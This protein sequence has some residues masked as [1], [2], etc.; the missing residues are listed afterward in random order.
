MRI[1]FYAPLKPPTHPTPSGDRR[2]ARL[3]MEA[4]RLAGH[5]VQLVSEFRSFDATGDALRQT[6]L[7]DEG[8]VIARALVQSWLASAQQ[9]RP[10]LWFTYHLYYKAPDWLGPH[11][12]AA[13]GIAYAIS[14]ASYAPRR[15]GG[16]WA[17]GHEATRRAIERAALVLCPTRDDIACVQDAAGTATRVLQLAPFLDPALYRAAAQSRAAQRMALVGAHGLSDAVPWMLAPAMMRYGDKLASYRMLAEVL[18]LLADVPW[19]LVV[20]GD[21]AARAEVLGLLEAAGP[22]RICWVGLCTEEAMA[23]LYAACDLCIWP[24]VNEAYG[25][26][27]LEAQAAGTAVVSCAVRGVPDVVCDGQTGLLAAQGDTPG[28]AERARRLLLDAP[29]RITMGRAAAQFVAQQRSTARAA[30]LLNL[31]FAGLPGG[32]S[33][34]TAATATKAAPAGVAPA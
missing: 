17:I 30:E 33:V 28:L 25:M 34:A 27:M 13:L 18:V 12:S 22:G 3:L 31:A 7:R 9:D 14:E 16:A 26:A 20:A 4:L 10:E 6:Q 29:R 8:G 21:G 15:A 24:A 11:V 2:V 19:H 32:G 5:S 23:A 1:A